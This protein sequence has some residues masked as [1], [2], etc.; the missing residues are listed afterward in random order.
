MWITETGQSL[1]SSPVPDQLGDLGFS[2]IWSWQLI[3]YIP[4]VSLQWQVDYTLVMLMKYKVAFL[5]PG[6]NSDANTNKRHL[7][8]DALWQTSETLI[9]FGP[10]YRQKFC[11]QRLLSLWRCMYMSN[12]NRS[13]VTAIIIPSSSSFSKLVLSME[14]VPP[15]STTASS[16]VL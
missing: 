3:Q 5:S 9:R 14:R 13:I 6:S 15:R 12:K 7:L 1:Y 2:A 11:Y 8:F 10:V 16:S 4:L